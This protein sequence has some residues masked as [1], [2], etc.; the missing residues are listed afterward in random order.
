MPKVEERPEQLYRRSEIVQLLKLSDASVDRL[1]A[2]GELQTL[3]LGPRSVRISQSSLA[4]FL[5]RARE[6]E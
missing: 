4:R 2:A 3:R 6:R 1:I 5:S